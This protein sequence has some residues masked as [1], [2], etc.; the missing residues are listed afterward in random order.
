MVGNIPSAAGC[1][2]PSGDDA[3][4]ALHPR[5]L[6][7]QATRP[8]PA[9]L[10]GAMVWLRRWKRTKQPPSLQ[11]CDLEEEEVTVNEEAAADGIETGA[12]SDGS[13]EFSPL[14]IPQEKVPQSAPEAPRSISTLVSWRGVAPKRTASAAAPS[15]SRA[16]ADTQADSLKPNSSAELSKID[17][18]KNRLRQ[19]RTKVLTGPSRSSGSEDGSAD[20]LMGIEPRADE[21]HLETLSSSTPAPAVSANDQLG[22]AGDTPPRTERRRAA[23]SSGWSRV[24]SIFR[25]A[26]WSASNPAEREEVAEDSPTDGRDLATNQPAGELQSDA[27]STPLSEEGAELGNGGRIHDARAWGVR[28][29]FIAAWHSLWNKRSSKQGAGATV[30]VV[31][32]GPRRW[33]Q[34]VKG[35]GVGAHPPGWC[36]AGGGGDASE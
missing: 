17:L 33:I 20:K 8:D 36:P 28:R 14:A 35:T 23:S 19:M 29:S 34:Q 31:G 21:E 13:A 27:S 32:G 1:D 12:Y 26:S 25:S 18:L 30:H 7:C 10:G 9:V 2:E 15:Q 6:Q 16:A 4:H 11:P 3:A 24:A 22:D 5:R